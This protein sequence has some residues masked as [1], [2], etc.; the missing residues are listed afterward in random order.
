M[1]V[2]IDDFNREYGLVSDDAENGILAACTEDRDWATEMGRE[3][4]VDMFYESGRQS[5]WKAIRHCI[6]TDQPLTANSIA[7]ASRIVGNGVQVKYV[8]AILDSGMP[9]VRDR[10]YSVNEVKNLH[11]LRFMLEVA[12]W[13]LDQVQ[14]RPDLTKLHAEMT[15]RLAIASQISKSDRWLDF[16][17]IDEVYK[18]VMSPTESDLKYHLFPW[19]F[20]GINNMVGPAVSQNLYLLAAPD[21]VGKSAMA[22]QVG[23]HWA[24]MSDSHIAMVTLEDTLQHKLRR[25]IVRWARVPFRDLRQG[26]TPEQI[27]RVEQAR[28]R[29]KAW[30]GKLHI[31]EALGDMS[32]PQILADVERRMAQYP[33]RA[34]IVDYMGL[35]DYDSSRGRMFGSKSFLY[36]EYDVMRLKH[37]ARKHN[38]AVLAVAQMT[39]EGLGEAKPT[40]KAIYGGARTYQVAQG[41]LLLHREKCKRQEGEQDA[42]GRTV[43]QYDGYSSRGVIYVDKANEGVTG[44]CEMFFDGEFYTWEDWN[45]QSSAAEPQEDGDDIMAILGF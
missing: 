17:M 43:A 26:L 9:F 25:R 23:E 36:Q 18:A 27:E 3:I 15:E 4:T 7:S 33:I 16:A 8:K 32:I 19:P 21:G 37:F 28:A 1:S 20:D 10:D 6:A 11:S 22:A 35:Q 41:V 44:Q 45:G 2:P 38:V 29:T 39:K 34:L 5:I 12:E 14:E 30:E 24:D 31:H 40:R 13:L 42:S